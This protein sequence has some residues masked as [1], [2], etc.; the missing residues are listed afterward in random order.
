[1]SPGRETDQ[2]KPA[3][4]SNEVQLAGDGFD[5]LTQIGE[6]TRPRL[7]NVSLPAA[8]V[9]VHA[10]PERARRLG[11]V[12]ESNQGGLTLTAIKAMPVWEAFSPLQ[13]T[14][15]EALLT[16]DDMRSKLTRWGLMNKVSEAGFADATPQ[17]QAKRLFE[18][19]SSTPVLPG[20][21]AL[22]LSDSTRPPLKYFLDAGT[23]VPG[24][25]FR[26]KETDANKFKLTVADKDSHISIYEPQDKVYSRPHQHTADEVASAVAALPRESRALVSSIRLNPDANPDDAAWAMIYGTSGFT[27]FMS[28][29]SKG[30]L[31]I[32]PTRDPNPVKNIMENLNHEAGHVWS[33]KLWGD[34]ENGPLWGA[35]R[36]AVAADGLPVSD[37]GKSSLREDVAEST[38]M[39]LSTRGTPRFEK[40]RAMYPNRFAILMKQFPGDSVT[41]I[42][43]HLS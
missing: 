42:I 12:N 36:K 15:L 3:A 39:F 20:N 23:L 7:T 13:K 28:C 30:T 10:G 2:P 4:S 38:A 18:A 26:T 32:Y 25:K 16:G 9:N 21:I 17:E 33:L 14:Q 27:S 24:F 22:E 40:Y 11:V 35:W 29:D 31:D 8:A 41:G 1:M 37:Y 6:H 34:D 19:L 5:P 43:D